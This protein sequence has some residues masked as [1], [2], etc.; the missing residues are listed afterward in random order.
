M[1]L[2]SSSLLLLLLLLLISNYYTF[3]AVS[4]LRLVGVNSTHAGNLEVLR[5][6]LW[7]AVCDT[8]WDKRDADVACRQLGFGSALAALKDSPFGATHPLTIWL[9]ELRCRGSEVFLTNCPH[10]GW[11][12]GACYHG[13]QAGLV[14]SE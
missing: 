12:T 14:C 4:D 6:G 1:L 11:G 2:S 10:A 7:G 5:D 8:S 3:I 13:H 9:D